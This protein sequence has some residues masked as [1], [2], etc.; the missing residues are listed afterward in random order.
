MIEST[1]PSYE[2]LEAQAAAMRAALEDVW[3]V[4][5]KEHWQQVGVAL[6]KEAGKQL[7]EE[8]EKTRYLRDLLRQPAAYLTEVLH[9]HEQQVLILKRSAKSVFDSDDDCL[10]FI[11]KLGNLREAHNALQAV[12]AT[13]ERIGRMKA[14]L[15]EI[16]AYGKFR[17][18]HEDLT[19]AKKAELHALTKEIPRKAHR[20][21]NFSSLPETTDPVVDE[22]LAV[23]RRYE[24]AL[25][26]IAT[27]AE[28]YS[29]EQ[30]DLEISHALMVEMPHDAQEALYP[31]DY[32]QD[33]DFDLDLAHDSE[34][35]HLPPLPF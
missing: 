8:L 14:A 19:E 15:E 6:E 4:C 32:S 28:D 2:E 33:D 23:A 24:E 18:V 3:S 7:V 9:R 25:R 21:L 26:Q 31:P 16:E 5:S 12:E 29:E 13:P 10:E 20:A 27:R 35:G 17:P 11:L 1:K 22:S 30:P 34:K